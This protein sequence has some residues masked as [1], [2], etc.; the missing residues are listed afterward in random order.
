LQR[1]GCHVW[2]AEDRGHP[3]PRSPGFM[4][5][6]TVNQMMTDRLPLTG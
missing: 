4:F 6:R 2:T 3:H 5:W 1:A